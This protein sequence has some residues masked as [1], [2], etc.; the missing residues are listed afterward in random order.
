MGQMSDQVAQA[1][2]IGELPGPRESNHE[3][4]VARL[5]RLQIL[6]RGIGRIGHHNDFAT[7]PRQD[8]LLKH[9]PKQHLLGLI[10]RRALAPHQAKGQRDAIDI[11]LRQQHDY[12]QAKSVGS[13]LVEPPALGPGILLRAFPLSV[14]S[15]TRYR[16]PAWG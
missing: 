9:L 6:T 3:P 14:L 5:N 7:P 1:V 13:I 10:A 2:T 8:N 15:A 11:P 12:V 16:T 4:P